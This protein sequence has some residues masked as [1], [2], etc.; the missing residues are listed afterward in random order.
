MYCEKCG[1]QIDENARF[2]SACGRKTTL[3][4][5]RTEG[6]LNKFF[7]RIKRGK[8]CF[9]MYFVIALILVF[10]SGFGYSAHVYSKSPE[11][12]IYGAV[13][14]MKDHNYEKTKEFVNVDAIVNNRVDAITNEMLNSAELKDNPFAGFAYMLVDSLKPK[15]ASSVH[16]VLKNAVESRDNV[17]EQVSKP[18]VLLFTIKKKY[19]DV[20]LEQTVKERDKTVFRFKKGTDIDLL[21]TM[22]KNGGNW[23]IVDISGFDLLSEKNARYLIH[24]VKN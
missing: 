23:Q 14:A 21:I 22:T 24:A 12:S 13:S 10:L 6:F 3:N 1:A 15:L 8:H 4:K 11:A 9:A 7:G 18:Q 19:K 17:F 20:S 2:C 5:V 16:A